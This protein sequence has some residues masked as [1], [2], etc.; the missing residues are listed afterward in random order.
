[1]RKKREMISEEREM[2][3]E[4]RAGRYSQGPQ[5]PPNAKLEKENKRRDKE[6]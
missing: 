1:M 6:K 3:S 2:I 5:L 4:E